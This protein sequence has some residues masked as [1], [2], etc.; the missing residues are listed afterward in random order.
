MTSLEK[1][2]HNALKRKSYGKR[3]K[4]K[5]KR[6]RKSSSRARTRTRTIARVVY[7]APRKKAKRAKRPKKGGKLHGRAKAAFLRRMARGRKRAR[8]RY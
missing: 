5:S 4:R 7:R 3:K 6:R 1:S 2:I 8:G